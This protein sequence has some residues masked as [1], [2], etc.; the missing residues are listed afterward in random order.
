MWYKQLGFKLNI[1]KELQI[2]G[3]CIFGAD[4]KDFD[5]ATF[6][7]SKIKAPF[8]CKYYFLDCGA[9]FFSEH[10]PFNLDIFWVLVKFVDNL[11]AL[12]LHIIRKVHKTVNGFF[13]DRYIFIQSFESFPDG[14]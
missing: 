6:G 4:G 7:V 12:Y 9:S 14:I 8:I 1:V 10:F 2:F 3:L 5:A 11:F 13:V